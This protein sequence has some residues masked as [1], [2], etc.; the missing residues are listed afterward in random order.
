MRL[1]TLQH[2][3]GETLELIEQRAQTKVARINDAKSLIFDSIAES[4]D[5]LPRLDD[6]S[7][8]RHGAT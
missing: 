5:T 1:H 6:P 7:G 8:I 2:G 3:A 4:L